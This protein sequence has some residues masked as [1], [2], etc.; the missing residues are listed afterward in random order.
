MI[1]TAGLKSINIVAAMCSTGEVFYSVNCGMTNS[2]TFC[3]FLVKLVEHLDAF[4]ESWRS[5]SVLMLDNAG[6]H[7]SSF[8]QGVMKSLHLPALYLGPYH[9]RLAPV[10]M[11]FNYVKSRD[12]NPLLSKTGGW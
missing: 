7:R 10:E 11:L 2:E 5:H 4:D 3:F 12:L 1:E 9:F 8:T 6:Y